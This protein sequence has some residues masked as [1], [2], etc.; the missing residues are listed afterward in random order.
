MPERK[1]LESSRLVINRKAAGRGFKPRPRL[2]DTNPRLP[3]PSALGKILSFGF[4]MQKEEGG[5]MS[6]IVNFDRLAQP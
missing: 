3:E 2:H 6:S 4:S 5:L 1:A